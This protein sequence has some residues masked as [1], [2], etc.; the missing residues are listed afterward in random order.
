MTIMNC[1]VCGAW[2]TVSKVAEARGHLKCG[3]CAHTSCVPALKTVG[4]SSKLGRVGKWA[5]AGAIWLGTLVLISL[6]WRGGQLPGVPVQPV[7]A[8]NAAPPAPE[9]ATIASEPALGGWRSVPEAGDASLLGVGEEWG[10]MMA[11]PGVWS[12]KND[13]LA[14]KSTDEINQSP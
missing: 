8:P 7:L 12:W 3:V 4:G 13:A 10:A 1:P 2:T 6:L 5:G 14:P 11:H 9:A